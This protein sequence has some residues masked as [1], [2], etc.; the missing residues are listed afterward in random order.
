MN[1]ADAMTAI[2]RT[3]RPGRYVAVRIPSL[4]TESQPCP[5]IPLR[6]RR[7]NSQVAAHSDASNKAEP[8]PKNAP[9]R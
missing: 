9:T 1:V 7:R 4:D 5:S 3:L 8:A 2:E 6:A